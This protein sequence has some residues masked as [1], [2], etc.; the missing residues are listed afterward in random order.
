MKNWILASVAATALAGA[1]VAQ[2]A[3]AASGDAPG[4]TMKRQHGPSGQVRAALFEA[5]IAGMKAALKLTSEQEKAW[6][7]FEA[8][9]RSAEDGP[10]GGG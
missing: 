8:S 9:V 1:G 4:A 7:P 2:Y 10:H 5:R 3:F 6:A